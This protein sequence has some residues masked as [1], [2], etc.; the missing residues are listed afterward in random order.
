[1]LRSGA[2]ASGG[3]GA[4]SAGP[5]RRGFQANLPAAL[6]E[7]NYLAGWGEGLRATAADGRGGTGGPLESRHYP[8]R[9]RRADGGG[10]RPTAAY[11]PMDQGGRPG[12]ADGG[13]ISVAGPERPA[14]LPAS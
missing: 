8:A 4:R 6:D 1:M 7:P 13:T 9:A 14:A 12:T 10:I 3:A 5:H 2:A 11:L